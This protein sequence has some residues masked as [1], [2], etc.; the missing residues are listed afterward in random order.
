MLPTVVSKR[1]VLL[2]GGET[3]EMPGFYPE[4]EYDIAGFAVGVVDKAK[5]LTGSNI[6]EGDILLGLPSS[7]I[8]SNGFSLVRKSILYRRRL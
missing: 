8:H 2:I 3:A 5:A 4:D 7:G 6:N 1:V